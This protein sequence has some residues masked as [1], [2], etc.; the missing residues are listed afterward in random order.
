MSILVRC[1]TEAPPNDPTERKYTRSAERRKAAKDKISP[2]LAALDAD[3]ALCVEEFRRRLR[4]ERYSE[5]TVKTY[6]EALSTLL[7]FIHPKPFGAIE[8]HDL[9]NFNNDYILKR[10]TAPHFKIRW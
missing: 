3:G 9:V 2:G 4:S 10:A 1:S 8:N 7:R 6:A 5:N